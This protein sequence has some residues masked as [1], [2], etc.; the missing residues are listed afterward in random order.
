MR[1]INKLCRLQWTN[2][3]SVLY[4]RSECNCV[5]VAND[6]DGLESRNRKRWRSQQSPNDNVY[7]PFVPSDSF[8]VCNSRQHTTISDIPL[9]LSFCLYF[10][11]STYTI[12]MNLHCWHLNTQVAKPNRNIL[13]MIWTCFCVGYRCWCCHCWY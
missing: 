9:V 2:Q 13:Y 10:I 7:T 3:F 8:R 5:Y 1:C 11:Y 4:M 6:E 12:C